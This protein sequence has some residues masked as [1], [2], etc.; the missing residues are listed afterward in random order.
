MEGTKDA[1]KRENPR[2]IIKMANV[3]RVDKEGNV[4]IVFNGDRYY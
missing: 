2:P 3:E 1:K 4:Y